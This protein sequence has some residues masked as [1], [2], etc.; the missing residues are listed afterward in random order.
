MDENRVA[1]ISQSH[2]L[3]YNILGQHIFRALLLCCTV[4][5]TDPHVESGVS[6]GVAGKVADA[7]PWAR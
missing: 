3:F 2:G 5:R 6:C 4:T 7:L 1:Y